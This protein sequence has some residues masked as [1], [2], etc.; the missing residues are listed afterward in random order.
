MRIIAG[1][2][3]RRQLVTVPGTDVTRP[4]SDRV[5]ES[6]FNIIASEIP[7]AI[8]VDLFAGSGALGIEALSRG[9]K[10]VS[11]VEK[12]PTALSCIRKNLTAIGETQNN[13]VVCSADVSLFLKSP[14]ALFASQDTR[15]VFAASTDVIFADPPYE[16][17]WYNEA[18]HL[19]EAS[20]LC[21]SAT[22]AVIEMAHTR[23]LLADDTLP[24]DLEGARTY[25]KTRIE[26]WRRR[27]TTP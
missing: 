26:L 8:V 6:I 1:K 16:S 7:G 3:K 22:L 23:Q 24:W 11:F 10:A 12:N 5:R 25:G 19:L 27:G 17:A 18:L 4:T 2:H 13:V 15:N 9:A 14:T 21:H 20:G